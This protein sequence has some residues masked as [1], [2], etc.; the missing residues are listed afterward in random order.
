[1]GLLASASG[2]SAETMNHR[3]TVTVL[4]TVLA[5]C[6]S[7]SFSGRAP[8][9]DGGGGGNDATVG[10]GG[11]VDP[12]KSYVRVAHLVAGGPA[13]NACVKSHAVAGYE[14]APIL[15]SSGGD[16][17]AGL[18][19]TQVTRYLPV[20]PG[21]WDVKVVAATET[22]C[23]AAATVVESTTLPSLTGGQFATIGAM[24]AP[25]TGDA[26]TAGLQVKAFV[27]ETASTAQSK[28]RLVHASSNAPSP[29]DGNVG[30]GAYVQTLF[31][32]VAFGS[33][34][35]SPTGDAGSGVE[36]TSNGYY[37]S[38]AAIANQ[39]V[40][41]NANNNTATAFILDNVNVAAAQSATVYAINGTEADSVQ[42]LVCPDA[43]IT[44]AA[45]SDCTVVMPRALTNA[46]HVR[47]AHLS[48]NAP[49]VDV[50]VKGGAPDTA[51]TSADKPLFA[52]LIGVTGGLTSNQVSRYVDIASGAYVYKVVA[53]GAAD[54]TAT[55]VSSSLSGAV[56]LLNNAAGSYSTL[57]VFGNPAVDGGASTLEVVR[58][59]DAVRPGNTDVTARFIHA[60]SGS[61][62]VLVKKQGDTTNIVP[63][64]AYKA[65]GT[66]T[67]PAATYQN[68]NL[69]VRVVAG[70]AVVVKVPAV[71]FTGGSVNTLFVVTASGAARGLICEDTAVSMGAMS[72]CSIP[73]N[74]TN[75]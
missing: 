26:G 19:F 27:D 4:S 47:I 72:T 30:S 60:I 40:S 11:A 1:M 66:Y 31:D 8:G 74:Q 63:T 24:S 54:C 7:D 12:T 58:F 6:S 56:T 75:L 37:V 69:E 10:E 42:A 70:E 36:L 57:G 16:A 18:T 51:F 3:F 61:G 29:V 48:P 50:C 62:A 22:D 2:L 13:V 65:A 59:A 49:A 17:G 67:D 53:A 9:V 52:N 39:L 15:T 23:A 35:V 68:A 34:A 44:T 14:G 71:T 21:Q 5:A 55:A 33:A 45:L 38:E 20:E 73:A 41:V 25:S 64:L 28:L 43:A 46:A 32:A